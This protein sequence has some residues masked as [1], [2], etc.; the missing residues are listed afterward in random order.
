VSSNVDAS[1][2]DTFDVSIYDARNKQKI[3]QLPPLAHRLTLL[4]T[5]R[6]IEEKEIINKKKEKRTRDKQDL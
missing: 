2:E 5:P 3:H 1:D 6:F 4:A